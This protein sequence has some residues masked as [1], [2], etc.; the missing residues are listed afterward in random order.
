MKFVPMTSAQ[1]RLG[2]SI[3]TAAPRRRRT[4]ASTETAVRETPRITVSRLFDPWMLAVGFRHST[5]VSRPAGAASRLVGLHTPPSTYSRPPIVTGANSQGTV[6]E[7]ATASGTLA[8]GDPGLPNTTRRPLR[9]ST[10]A[11]RNRPSKRGARR[12]ML[13]CRSRSVWL[14]R[15]RRRSR[16]ARATAPPGAASPRASGAK[17][18]AAARPQAP[19]RRAAASPAAANP[20]TGRAP[21]DGAIS[22]SASNEDGR[23]GDCPATR[24]AATIEP[25]DVPTK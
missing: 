3:W 19:A 8:R 21:L 6:H 16:T 4:S 18:A 20:S 9:R 1:S 5:C 17:V 12:S 13:R 24:C 15:G 23:R 7:A 2:A 25:A 22:S 11:T 10:A 14:G